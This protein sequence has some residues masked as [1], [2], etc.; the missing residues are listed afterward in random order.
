MSTRMGYLMPN[1]FGSVGVGKQRSAD[2]HVLADAHGKGMAVA[3]A[4]ACAVRR[5]YIRRRS[6]LSALRVARRPMTSSRQI[7]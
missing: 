7:K 4:L 2:Q 3:R 5:P 1:R 6:M